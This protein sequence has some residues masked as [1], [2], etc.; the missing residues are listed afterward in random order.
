L[1]QSGGDP[2][3]DC[4]YNH[5]PLL[6]RALCQTG[7]DL[8]ESYFSVLIH[9]DMGFWTGSGGDRSEHLIGNRVKITGN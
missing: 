6:L 9:K 4:V 3:I 5:S 1:A 8:D 2:P 7:R